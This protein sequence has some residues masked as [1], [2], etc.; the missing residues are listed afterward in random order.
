[1]GQA[2]EAINSK[3]KKKFLK[4]KKNQEQQEKVNKGV[5]L[6]SSDWSDIHE[7]FAKEWFGETYQRMWEKNCL[8]REDAKEW[9]KV[10]FSPRDYLAVIAWGIKGYAAIIAYRWIKLGFKPSESWFVY[11]IEGKGYHL[12]NTDPEKVRKEFEDWFKKREEDAQTYV[13]EEYP[14]SKRGKITKLD[15]SKKY[16][17]GSLH[18]ERFG[19]LTIFDCS[20]N[21]LTSLKLIPFLNPAK[22]KWLSIGDNDFPSSDNDLGTFS[23]FINL[24]GL[25]I[26]SPY[27]TRVR[28]IGSLQPLQP[29][30]KLK[31][32]DIKN[33][34]LTGGLEFLS[35]S[36]EEFYCGGTKLA[37][38]LEDYGSPNDGN[39]IDSGKNY[40]NLLLEWRRQN[41]L[42]QLQTQIQ[43]PP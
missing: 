31:Y 35:D 5:E 19:N 34:E 23:V 33:T 12:G 4:M 3:N 39:Y 14:L 40:I 26:G 10:G 29:L 11:Y 32:L 43:V 20:I 7:D 17:A 25:N 16:L 15:I 2:I 41:E 13:D 24:E 22:L 27:Q 38:K 37:E 8:T 21:N 42:S 1:M 9:I 36:L 18:L 28:W 6:K 30:T